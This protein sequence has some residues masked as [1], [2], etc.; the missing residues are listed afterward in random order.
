MLRPAIMPPACDCPGDSDA[1]PR[2]AMKPASPRPISFLSIF[3][4]IDD[5]PSV[6]KLEIGALPNERWSGTRRFTIKDRY[7][8]KTRGEI[9]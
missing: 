5:S 6:V 1:A 3:Y 8:E 9:A 4:R 2:K 7:P